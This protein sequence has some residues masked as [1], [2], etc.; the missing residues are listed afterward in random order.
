[1]EHRKHMKIAGKRNP[2]TK[3]F[4]DDSNNQNHHRPELPSSNRNHEYE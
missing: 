2:T 1:M 4:L 3:E